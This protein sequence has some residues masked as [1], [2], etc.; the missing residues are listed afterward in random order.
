MSF[1]NH[2]TANENDYGIVFQSIVCCPI[3]DNKG[4]IYGCVQVVNRSNGEKSFSQED[5]L[6]LVRNSFLR[7]HACLSVLFSSSIHSLTPFTFLFF[8]PLPQLK[9]IHPQNDFSAHL[10]P[11][12]EAWLTF[13]DT[14]TLLEKHL[15]EAVSGERKMVELIAFLLSIGGT[16]LREAI[17]ED[18]AIELLSQA[19]K[20]DNHE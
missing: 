1:W 14:K 12:V 19:A 7:F 10:G 8:L 13:F 9:K 3:Q 17:G 11:I 18:L 2:L 20:P 4:N 6:Q 15:E 5:E 16:S